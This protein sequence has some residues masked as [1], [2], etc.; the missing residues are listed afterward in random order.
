MN[1]QTGK[2]GRKVKEGFQKWNKREV[3]EIGGKMF[4]WT[5]NEDDYIETV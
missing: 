3:D 1:F 2:E 5:A 4:L